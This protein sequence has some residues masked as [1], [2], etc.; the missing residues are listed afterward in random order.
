MARRDQPMI[1]FS[2][3]KVLI[4][5]G[6]GFIGSNL[7]IRLADLGADVTVVDSMLAQYGGNLANLD[8]H[9][10]RLHINFS[11]IRDS[12]TLSYLV[13]DVDIIYSMAGQTS[14]V[15]SMHDPF[16]DLEINCS[17]QLSILECC[18]K[19]NPQVEIL[20]A[21]TRQIYGRPQYLPV[22]ESHPIVPVDV[23]GINKYAA[24]MYYTLYH[25]VH[26]MR[27]TS[28]RLTNTYG[29]RQHLRDN[30]Q[31][32]VGIFLR[33]ALSGEQL[34]VFG[35]GQQLRDFNYVDDVVDAFLMATG[36]EDL[37]GGA[38]NLGHGDKHSLL[39][40]VQTL[41]E[42]T[43]VSYEIVPF[44]PEH[45]AIDIG[46][47]YADFSLFSDK[48]TWVPQVDLKSGLERTVNYFKTRQNLYW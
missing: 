13:R 9:Q 38:F 34:R 39:E 5:G 43:D 42:F 3:K 21:S 4:L 16:T 10:D 32:F 48:T 40:F 31:G 29:P 22:D 28:L 27:C 44:P 6:M 45:K 26:G 20:Y 24:E 12:H 23:N 8:G 25:K 2:G 14:H 7:A 47:Y 46:D 1:E 30:K 33:L 11:D 37:H 19:F 36:R 18:R 41:A 15:E 17:S 35:D